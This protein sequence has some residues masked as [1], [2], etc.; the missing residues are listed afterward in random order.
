M[1]FYNARMKGKNTLKDKMRKLYL[2]LLN[3]EE[4]FFRKSKFIHPR[5]DICKVGSGTLIKT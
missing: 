1:G 2:F 3:E 5:E 4:S